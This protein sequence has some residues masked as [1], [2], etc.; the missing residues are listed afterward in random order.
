MNARLMGDRIR[1]CESEAVDQALALARYFSQKGLER[2]AKWRS[3]RVD[4]AKDD[5]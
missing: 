3:T 2:R 1:D 4:L 5:F